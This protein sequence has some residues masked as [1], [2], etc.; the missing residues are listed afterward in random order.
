M[1]GIPVG[2]EKF[3]NIEAFNDVFIL[4]KRQFIE[5]S[6]MEIQLECNFQIEDGN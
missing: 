1:I 3:K 5:T 4:K 2:S 6:S